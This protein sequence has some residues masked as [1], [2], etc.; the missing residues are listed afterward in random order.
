M[1][2]TVD[3]LTPCALAIRRQLHCVIPL[4]L[5]CSVAWKINLI[6]SAE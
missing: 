3:L 1:L 2:L 5:V 4:G 6:L